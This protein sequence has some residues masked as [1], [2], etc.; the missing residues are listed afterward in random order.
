[1]ILVIACDEQLSTGLDLYTDLLHC[2]MY[3]V[4]KGKK[5][6]VHSGTQPR[7]CVHLK[8][9]YVEHISF[10]ACLPLQLYQNSV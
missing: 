4:F 3:L 5:H 1:M 6:E 2:F 8:S 7:L 9:Q 10:F